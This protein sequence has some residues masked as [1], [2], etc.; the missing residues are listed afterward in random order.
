MTETENRILQLL[1][2]LEQAVNSMAKANPKPN[3]LPI[4]ARLD[5]L[6]SQLPA[7]SDPDLI[8]YMRRK[9]YQKAQLL[10]QG[11]KAS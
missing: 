8:H 11:V 5:E 10:L 1:L 3:L 7:D 9:S 6:A 2:E 4:C